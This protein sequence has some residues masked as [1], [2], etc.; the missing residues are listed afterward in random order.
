MRVVAIDDS[1][2]D[3]DVVLI[4]IK[5]NHKLSFSSSSDDVDDE[6]MDE[7]YSVPNRLKNTEGSAFQPQIIS[8]KRKRSNPD[9]T[10]DLR[11]LDDFTY[12]IEE[13]DDDG[14][15]LKK[16]PQCGFTADYN[17][18]EYCNHCSFR[19]HKTVYRNGQKKTISFYKNQ[20]RIEPIDDSN[21]IS[22]EDLN[23]S[24]D[25]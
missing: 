6:S 23:Y 17:S 3:S 2:S 1:S 24:T 8:G 9:Y 19:F 10:I 16:C 18:Q 25:E 11:S 13:A 15:K 12:G 22:D 21:V 7:Q 4:R 14:I 5:R 20:I